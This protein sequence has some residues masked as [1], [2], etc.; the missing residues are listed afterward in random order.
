M[1]VLVTLY[2]FGLGG[3]ETYT[4]TVAEQFERLGH[5]VTVYAGAASREGLELAAARGLALKI[6][7]VPPLDGVDAVLAQDTASACLI[8]SR[9]AGIRQVFVSHGLSPFEHLAATLR[10]A[11]PVVAMNDRI[12]RHAAKG[13]SHAEVVRLRQPIDIMRFHPHG[14]CRPRPRRVLALGNYLEGPRRRMLENACGQLGLELDQRGGTNEPI[15]APETALIEADVVVGYG[16][17]ILEA[18]AMGRPA[19][20]WDHAGGDGWVTPESYA[21]LEA[22]GFAGGATPSVIDADRLRADLSNYR[23]E[24]GSLGC[25]LVCMHHSAT[26]H[27]EALLDLLCAGESPAFS[28]DLDAIAMLVRAEARAASRAGALEFELRR[29]AA[30]RDAQSARADEA[31]AELGALRESRSWRVMEPLRR[32]RRL[33]RR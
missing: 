22:D 5:R 17:A 31:E 3:S 10:P 25:D 19:Y 20:V 27:A 18:M 16:R 7:Q 28:G 26:D 32:V 12:A 33:L 24:L 13:A 15:I 8:A 29:A 21:A 1:H 14:D 23:P 30:E 9:R 11:P 2:Q 4:A 6:G